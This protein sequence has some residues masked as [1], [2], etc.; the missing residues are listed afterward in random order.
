VA[1]PENLKVK[2]PTLKPKKIGPHPPP[3]PKATLSGFLH[4]IERL[5]IEVL[6]SQTPPPLHPHPLSRCRSEMPY[7]SA[8]TA[9][10]ETIASTRHVIL[11]T[12]HHLASPGTKPH[13]IEVPVLIKSRS[14]SRKL[15]PT[16]SFSARHIH[17]VVATSCC[18][19]CVSIGSTSVP[20]SGQPTRAKRE[21]EREREQVP[22]E[23]PKKRHL[24]LG[25]RCA[26]ARWEWWWW[27]RVC[28]FLAIIQRKRFSQI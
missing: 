2:P 27:W 14:A 26:F 28:F 17:L 7:A 4:G 24:D 1:P 20:T 11:D 9:F 10:K 13:T 16:C 21:R 15:P 23:T 18:C 22:I 19:C 3:P 5:D 25:P 12:C 6:T 8:I